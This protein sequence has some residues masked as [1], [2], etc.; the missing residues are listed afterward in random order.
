MRVCVILATFALALLG[1]ANAGA[2][3]PVT[4][5]GDHVTAGP[6]AA[7]TFNVTGH[8]DEPIGAIGVS[9]KFDPE[10]VTP[11]SCQSTIA[12][13]YKG[14]GEGELRMNTV[15]L[16]GFSGDIIFITIVFEAADTPGTH[17]IDVDVTAISDT[18]GYSLEGQLTV[19]DG[20]VTID[21]GTVT[22]PPGDANCDSTVDAADGLSVLA[23][24]AG[25]GNTE[26][27]A[28]AD[29]NCDDKVNATDALAILRQIGGLPVELPAGCD[30][31]A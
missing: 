17:V 11:V 26:C 23:G 4:V 22:T 28:L 7:V 3:G 1:V 30:P 20:S 24:L 5:S 6:G 14:A 21:G 29:V 9:V 2:G 15:S 31:V 16:N 10:S 27:F 13:C 18:A 8:A 25:A 19:T 12:L